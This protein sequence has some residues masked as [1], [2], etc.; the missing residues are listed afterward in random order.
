MNQMTKYLIQIFCIFLLASCSLSPGMREPTNLNTNVNIYDITPEI[1][2]QNESINA[3]ENYKISTGDNLSIVVF[4]Q[5]DFF[6]ITNVTQNNPYTSK[7][8]DSNGEIYFP[9]AG[10]IKASGH[11]VAEVR[12]KVTKKLSENFKDPQ[13][14]VSIIKFNNKRNLYILGEVKRPK[15]INVGLVPLSLADAISEAQGLNTNTARGN[16]V[17]VIRSRDQSVYR[18]DMRNASS[19]LLAGQFKLLPGDIIF[20]GPADI[21][22]WNRFV[23][24]LFPFASFLTQVENLN[25]N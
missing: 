14:D 13:V 11:T 25:S 10:T 19:F 22:K 4:G 23:S 6:P 9:F 12:N 2:A 20:V 17:F 1:L 5:P 3:F 8:V 24:Q 7:L 15:T 16:R 21:T 18:A